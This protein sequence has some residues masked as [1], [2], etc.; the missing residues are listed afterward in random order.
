MNGYDWGL[1]LAE[2]HFTSEFLE[3]RKLKENLVFKLSNEEI[4]KFAHLYLLEIKCQK[5]N[6][7]I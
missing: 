4:I 6:L 5:K 1:M 3:L 2:E 7:I